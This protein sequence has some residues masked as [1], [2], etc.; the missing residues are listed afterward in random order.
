MSAIWIE[1]SRIPTIPGTK[2]HA[3][4]ITPLML[5][6]LHISLFTLLIVVAVI[7]AIVILAIKDRQLPWLIRKAKCRLRGYTLSARPIYYRR[8]AML[9]Q[10]FSELDVEVLRK[11]V[12]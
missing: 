1:A 12:R 2:A 8:R 5:L 11:T 7:F 6:I 9:L 10:S 3:A 4:A